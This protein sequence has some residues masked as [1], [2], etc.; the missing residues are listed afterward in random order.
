[1]INK[2]FEKKYWE[3]IELEKKIEILD[4]FLK[5]QNEKLKKEG[6]PVNEE[7]RIEM[8]K[9]IGVYPE[10]EI[11]KDEEEI[12]RMEL[13]WFPEFKNLTEEEIKKEKL[14]KEGNQ[15]EMLKT[16]IFSKFFNSKHLAIRTSY[17][18]DYFN[19][20]DNLI[21]D[22]ETGNVICAIDAIEATKGET[23]KEKISKILQRN[24][25]GGVNL[26]YG[27]RFEKDKLVLGEIKNVPVFYLA[28]E[29][30]VLKEGL[31]NL[32][33][34]KEEKSETEKKLFKFFLSLFLLE[35]ESLKNISKH[36]PTSLRKRIENF[37]KM[38][39]EYNL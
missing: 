9:F 28:L 21:L 12:K 10:N 14:K 19:H 11:K 15:L 16:A 8:K 26:K 5:E 35:I 31:K 39:K 2:F 30:E 29:K 22:K 6:I 20:V 1:M 36:L 37:E 24:I 27:C 17:Y 7:S 38:I 25:D 23:F 34:L 33:S 18:D 3:Q 4:N 13:R 32:I